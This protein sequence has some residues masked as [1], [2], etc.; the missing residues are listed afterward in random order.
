MDRL[1]DDRDQFRRLLPA[2]FDETFKLISF[3]DKALAARSASVWAERMSRITGV[4]FR[5]K[6]DVYSSA[7]SAVAS[8]PSTAQPAK[9]AT[10]TVAGM[11]MPAPL[12]AAGQASVEAIRPGPNLLLDTVEMD[13]KNNTPR[14][15]TEFVTARLGLSYAY[16]DGVIII[17]R[18][19]TETFEIAALEGSKDFAMNLQGGS[20][21]GA[22]STTGATGNSQSN[23][24]I[25]EAGSL[26]IFNSFM[27]SLQQ[28]VA[29]VPGSSI[30]INQG[31]GRFAV[32]TT[33]EAMQRIRQVV[34]SENESLTRQVRIQMDIYSIT[35]KTAT[36]RRE[37]G[38]GAQFAD[39]QMGR[40]H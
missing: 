32:T 33:K 19:V 30:A 22:S 13:W 31:T 2:I 15:I 1:R 35:T 16:R 20:T 40:H 7:S 26:D 4:P 24:R 23:F 29:A 14:G 36:R 10:A 18:Y 39:L 9:P 38:R 17:E 5:I 28:M 8:S 3:E 12:A 25:D 6:Q 21:S 27:N 37:L 34:K 11:S